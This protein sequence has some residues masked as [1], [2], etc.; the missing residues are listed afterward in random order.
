[1]RDTTAVF[2]S[3]LYV[4]K[5]KKEEK[6]QLMEFLKFNPESYLKVLR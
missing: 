1:M 4:K 3:L 2:Y 5:K 6:K